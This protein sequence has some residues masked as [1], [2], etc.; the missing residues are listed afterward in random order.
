[1]A[2]PKQNTGEK[3]A[4]ERMEEAFWNML[5]EM[6]YTEMTCKELYGRAGVSH[7]TFYYYFHNIEDV[8]E[9]MLDRAMIKEMPA[10]LL[11]TIGTGQN[12]DETIRSVPNFD[13]RFR[14]VHFIAKNGGPLLKQ[15]FPEALAKFWFPALGIDEADLTPEDYVDFTFILNGA[16]AILGSDNITDISDV[17]A[18]VEREI[19]RGIVAKISHLRERS[20]KQEL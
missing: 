15:C 12:L 11:S 13:D 5:E 9:C 14:K 17:A 8:A 6:P 16:V 2:R 18:F 4:M 19:G 20:G 7:N 10:I 1:M 3:T